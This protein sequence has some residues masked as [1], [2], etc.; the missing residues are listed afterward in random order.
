MKTLMN[1]IE[2]FGTIN[3]SLVKQMLIRNSDLI[4]MSQ[5]PF[6]MNQLTEIETPSNAD[7]LYI[8]LSNFIEKKEMEDSESKV[9]IT[10]ERFNTINTFVVGLDDMLI[11]IERLREHLDNTNLSQFKLIGFHEDGNIYHEE[12][13]LITLFD[14]NEILLT[15]SIRKSDTN[16]YLSKLNLNSD[17]SIFMMTKYKSDYVGG[18]GTLTMMEILRLIKQ[19]KVTEQIKEMIETYSYEMV[20][21]RP[22]LSEVPFSDYRDFNNVCRLLTSLTEI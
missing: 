21:T 3:R 19:G 10:A 4:D 12:R 22:T 20:S 9:R 13:Q 14:E 8:F 7:H 17:L 5:L 15:R 1:H 2:S 16:K 11:T 6:N 18:R